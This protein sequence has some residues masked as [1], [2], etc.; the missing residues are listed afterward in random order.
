MK[1]APIQIN[2]L[3]HDGVP[4]IELTWQDEGVIEF[5]LKTDLFLDEASIEELPKLL[6][7]GFKELMK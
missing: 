7:E 4:M 2:I 1:L 5:K 3:D 6:K